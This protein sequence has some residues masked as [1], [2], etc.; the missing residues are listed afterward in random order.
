MRR[1]WTIALLLTV[2]AARLSAHPT[3]NTE[4]ILTLSE[5]SQFELTV[6]TDLDAMVL[7]LEALA[8]L[9]ASENLS[10]D[11]R[12]GRIV[13]LKRTLLDHVD[14]RFDDRRATLDLVAVERPR[15]RPGKVVVRLS[16][17]APATPSHATW[18]TDLIFGSYPF[19]VRTPPNREVFEWLNGR[20]QS[21]RYALDPIAGPAQ[22]SQIGRSIALGFTHILPFGL[23]HILF[24][25]GLFLLAQNTRTILLQVS[26]FTVAHS[27]TLGLAL[28]GVV[29]APAALVEPLIAL[30][31]AYVAFENLMT[32]SL[33]PWRVALVFAF[34]LLHGL[35]FA[36]ALRE[37]NLPRSAFLG[38]LVS[39][40]A[41]VEGGQLAVI[42][43]AAL[44][45]RAL[46]VP[47]A[48]YRRLIVR[49]ASLLIG[50]MGVFWVIQRLR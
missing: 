19:V 33:R 26:A 46:R 42:A 48:D 40:N 11:A 31:I 23:D 34:G 35:G 9:R 18:R 30:S 41:G 45:V 3:A 1:L 17:R 7:K 29:S 13:S 10:I 12:E 22:S 14:L 4:I 20:E 27:I 28:Y 5:Q 44:L 50:L 47:S 6:L 25:L 37:L 15:D 38:T 49:P 2:T 32:S 39:F 16:G 8:G 21:Q 43:A 36:E 24:V